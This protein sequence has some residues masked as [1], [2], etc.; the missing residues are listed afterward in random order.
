MKKVYNKN[1][2]RGLKLDALSYDERSQNVMLNKGV[3]IK[4]KV[5][6][7]EMRLINNQRC[8]IKFRCIYYYNKRWQW[9]GASDQY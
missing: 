7:E 1:R 9:Q 4:C 5:N 3:L 6:N 8:K 2:R